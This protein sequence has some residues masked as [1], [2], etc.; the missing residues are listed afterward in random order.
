MIDKLCIACISCVYLC[1]GA[2]TA[3]GSTV[4]D[5]IFYSVTLNGLSRNP[6]LFKDAFAFSEFLQYQ[7]L[8]RADIFT[9][10]DG[11]K[12]VPFLL[13]GDEPS[14]CA[15]QLLT[16]NLDL[17]T[18]TPLT[19][20]PLDVGR[21]FVPQE[22]D[23]VCLNFLLVPFDGTNLILDEIRV[24]RSTDF[25][26]VCPTLDKVQVTTV[27]FDELLPLDKWEYGDKIKELY[28]IH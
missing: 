22:E 10:E 26:V 20:A 15:L 18:T 1:F 23:K 14:T 19:E 4:D 24:A 16:A 13:C 11:Y 17:Y 8:V 3:Q 9:T 6:V 27:P 12:V 21:G 2:I 7:E 5:P 25:T 28:K